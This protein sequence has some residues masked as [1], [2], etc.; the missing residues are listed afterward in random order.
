MATVCVQCERAELQQVSVDLPGKVRG[1][2]YTVRM[3]GLACPRCGYKTI[4]GP[5][6]PEYGRL[7]ADKY[8]ANHGLLTS[9]EIRARRSS[10]G[11]SQQQFAD[12]LGVGVA[13]VKRWEMG[14]IQDER[15]ND[16]IIERT[17]ER[18]VSVGF[19][20]IGRF[21]VV[22]ST[23]CE[24]NWHQ[25]IPAKVFYVCLGTTEDPGVQDPGVEVYISRLAKESPPVQAQRRHGFLARSLGW[26]VHPNVIWLARESEERRL[27]GSGRRR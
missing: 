23:A 26:A 12:H 1:E 3:E 24:L 5:R 19:W 8:R 17:E 25:P 4:E 6:M 14:K 11:M 22:T 10:L 9:G 18:P 2:N 27:H 15:N 13:S 21:S 16:R 7:L 20:D